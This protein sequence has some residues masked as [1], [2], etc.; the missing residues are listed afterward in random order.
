MTKPK[1]LNIRQMYIDELAKIK[2][3]KEEK[4][5]FSFLKTIKNLTNPSLL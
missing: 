4:K 2:L 5:R 1:E 3:T